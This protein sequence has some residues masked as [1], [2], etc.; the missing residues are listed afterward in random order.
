MGRAT[1]GRDADTGDEGWVPVDPARRGGTIGE[2]LVPAEAT[3]G[4]AMA[5]EAAG[6]DGVAAAREAVGADP[7]ERS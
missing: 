1:G 3:E 7:A 5:A 6:E 2:G 4:A